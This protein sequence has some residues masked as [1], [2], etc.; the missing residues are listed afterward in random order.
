MQGGETHSHHPH[1]AL[2][3]SKCSGEFD[4]GFGGGYKVII[5]SFFE[6]SLGGGYGA[7]KCVDPQVVGRAFLFVHYP[8]DVVDDLKM[9]VHIHLDIAS[10][11][12]GDDLR[13]RDLFNFERVMDKQKS[14]TTTWGSRPVFL[15]FWN[16]S[17]HLLPL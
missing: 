13:P 5:M 15:L 2:A 14:S 6:L 12:D 8:L 16:C 1:P 17:K 7:D 3:R 9:P 10:A 4:A 11:G